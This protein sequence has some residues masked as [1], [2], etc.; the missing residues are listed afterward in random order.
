MVSVGFLLALLYVPLYVLAFFF[1]V[2]LIQLF[3]FDGELKAKLL[4]TLLFA[5]SL[6]AAHFIRKYSKRRASRLKVLAQSNAGTSPPN[7][8][9]RALNQSTAATATTR[10][11]EATV[12][13]MRPSL[14]ST[15]QAQPAPR[16]AASAS[17]NCP[18]CE[19]VIALDSTECPKC[20]ANF[21]IGSA[22]KLKP[23]RGPEP[24]DA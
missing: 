11:A 12:A 13:A 7:S 9:N 18:N 24:G 22:W 16:S 1:G 23:I 2:G 20:K 15:T 10:A 3:S 14:S 19:T 8:Q 17:G 21:G 4:A 5:A 6:V